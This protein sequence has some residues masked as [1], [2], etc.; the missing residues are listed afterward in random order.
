M[1]DIVVDAPLG[2]LVDDSKR[3]AWIAECRG[4]DSDRRCAGEQ[5]LD[6]VRAAC[7]SPGSDDGNTGMRARHFPHSAERDGFDRRT[8]HSTTTRA[9]TRGTRRRVDDKTHDGVD[10]REPGGARIERGAGYLDEVG[11]VRRQ[12]REHRRGTAEG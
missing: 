3:R 11:D 9:E 4:T 10:E 5:H 2:E 7:Y 8:R 1:F 12:L 6:R